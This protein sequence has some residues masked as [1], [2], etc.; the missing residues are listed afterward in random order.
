MRASFR[1]LAAALL[2]STTMAAP[3]QGASVTEPMP[4][5]TPLPI[6]AQSYPWLDHRH[7]LRPLDL[8]KAGFVEEEYL[9]SG[10]ANVYDWDPDPAKNIDIKYKD[11]PYTTRILMRRPAD[12]AKFSGTVVVETL[13]PARTYDMA[14]M[15]GWIAPRILERG[16]AWVGIS[17]PGVEASLQRF[18][19]ARYAKIS[20]ANPAPEGACPASGAPAGAPPRKNA[21]EPGLRL[22]AFAQLGEWLRGNE[23]GN[24]LS[25]HVKY[26][27][28]VGHTGGDVGPYV[29]SVGRSAR[30]PNGKP[31]YD[32]Y[33]MHSGTNVGLLNICGTKLAAND[34]R[35]LPG[36]AGVPVVMM[37]TMSDLPFAGRPDSDAPGDVFRIYD[38]PGS[39]HAD[40]FLFPFMADV[41]EQKRAV[42]PNLRTPV[43]DEW[44]F[45]RTCDI[46]DI[47][48]NDFPQGYLIDGALE[49]LERFARDGT[50]L[51][52]AARVPFAGGQPQLDPYGNPLGGIRTPWVDAPT[53]TFHFKLTGK[54]PTCARMGYEDIWPW[55]K[56]MAVYGN[57]DAYAA[58]VKT[59][60]DKL[61]ADRFVTASDAAKIRK[62]LLPDRP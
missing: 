8:E 51:P 18:D 25:G 2:L 15:F 42:D 57:Y 5:V 47:R 48:M 62:E 53:G 29:N 11:A 20:F 30:L 23:A 41:A 1:G 49:N 10:K 14:I 28:L 4:Q 43:T 7:T 6:T 55:Q 3:S 21:S 46:A 44:P 56:T 26:V 22:D 17:G 37:K 9:V 50:P 36:H 19:A 60:L 31:I 59:S 12:M 35:N 61:V 38:M 33:L 54:E 27:F 39:V 40:K 52:H 24:P 45:E 34:E 13:N 16:D 32:G 58:K